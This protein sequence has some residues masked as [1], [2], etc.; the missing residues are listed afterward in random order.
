VW[1]SL[2]GGRSGAVAPRFHFHFHR[3]TLALFPAPSVVTVSAGWREFEPTPPWHR[4]DGT[5]FER[6]ARRT[7]SENNG[8]RRRCLSIQK[9][10]RVTLATGAVT[11]L[12]Q[13]NEAGWVLLAVAVL[14]SPDSNPDASHAKNRDAR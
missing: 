13:G 6:D 10:L 2:G 1:W 11:L 12:S 7:A 9:R 4:H 14:A 5:R 8:P 3:A